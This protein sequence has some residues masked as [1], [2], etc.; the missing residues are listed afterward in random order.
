MKVI[1]EIDKDDDYQ[2]IERFLKF[3]QPSIMKHYL[4]KA[5]K[6]KEFIEFIDNEAIPVNKVVME[7]REL[8]NARERMP[9]RGTKPTIPQF[10]P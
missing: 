6:V 7:N 2:Q 8:R 1:V 3:L 10:T 9:P 5:N 4:D